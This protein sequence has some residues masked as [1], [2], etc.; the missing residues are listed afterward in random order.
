MKVEIAGFESRDFDVGGGVT[1]HAAIGGDGPPL[2]LL[3][4]APETHLMWQGVAP[5][6][7][8]HFTA[9]ASDLR[10]FGDSSKPPSLPDHS[11]QSFRAMAADQVNVMA[12]LGFDKFKVAGHDRGARTTYRMAL[13]HPD[14]IQRMMLMDIVPTLHFYENLTQRTATAYFHWFFLIQPAPVP[15]R[16]IMAHPAGY[17]GGRGGGPPAP[18][19]VKA[20]YRRCWEN[21]ETTRAICEDYRAAATIDLAHDRADLNRKV[22]CPAMIL[23][24]EKGLVGSAYDVM[25]IWQERCANLTG[26]GM[27]TNHF[28][29]EEAPDL[30]YETMM[31]FFS[32][33]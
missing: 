30:T 15:E 20:D 14:K 27:P 8:R 2:L 21:P 28:I 18:D 33:N 26:R 12:Q 6:L 4:G 13:D 31:A 5:R 7:A 29:P 22:E 32:Q 16:I 11:Q 19:W 10:G 1:I 3:H 23:W 17:Y 9:V 25:A 24:G